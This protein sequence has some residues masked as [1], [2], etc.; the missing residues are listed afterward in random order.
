MQRTVQKLE[1]TA[2]GKPR[3]DILRPRGGHLRGRRETTDFTLR[4]DLD[5][6]EAENGLARRRAAAGGQVS[7]AEGGKF[8]VFPQLHVREKKVHERRLPRRA[9][10]V[11][12][13][14]TERH[15]QGVPRLE[16][17]PEKGLLLN[18]FVVDG[19]KIS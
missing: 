7:D 17:T 16:Q 3:A 4:P 1:Q 18:P 15:G 12:R 5:V 6:R 2:D 10:V 11:V 9:A 14:G 19:G 13:H 8:G